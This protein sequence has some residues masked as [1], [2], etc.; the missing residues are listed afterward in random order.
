LLVLDVHPVA[1]LELQF[2]PKRFE[3]KDLA[4]GVI[5]A[6]D[7]DFILKKDVPGNGNVGKR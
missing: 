3:N 5:W 4:L 7:V 2:A 6:T 1:G